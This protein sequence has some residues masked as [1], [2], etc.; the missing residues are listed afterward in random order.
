M[1]RKGRCKAAFGID[2][3]GIPNRQR[4]RFVPN[5]NAAIS[6]NTLENVQ[7]QAN[8]ERAK[9]A[10][11]WANF[12]EMLGA[13]MVGKGISMAGSALGSM[14][15][16]AIGGTGGQLVNNLIT[17]GSQFGANLIANNAMFGLGG[18]VGG[19]LPIEIEGDETVEYPDG[20]V[21]QY[22]GPS[23]E[24]GG[25]PIDVPAGSEVYSKRIKKYNKT[26]S[27]RKAERTKHEDKIQRRS[28]NNKYDSLLKA[29][30]GKTSENNKKIDEQDKAV[31]TMI[32]DTITINEL[33]NRYKAAYGIPP[34]LDPELEAVMVKEGLIPS[35]EERLYGGQ[36]KES[37][38]A[39]NMDDL[40]NFTVTASRTPRPTNI[41]TLSTNGLMNVGPVSTSELT[42][43]KVPR[44][45]EPLSPVSYP[46]PNVFTDGLGN[47]APSTS[48]ITFPARRP[49]LQ[50]PVSYPNMPTITDGVGSASPSASEITLP[51]GK[52][53]PLDPIS[54]SGIPQ[55]TVTP[56]IT[57]KS[58]GESIPSY[59]QD[60]I[61]PDYSGA[62]KNVGK[63]VGNAVNG[64]LQNMPNAAEMFGMY[65]QIK[66]ANDLMNN[67]VQNLNATQ[68]NINPYE[69]YGEEGLN[70]LDTMAKYFTA[71][72]D[73]QYQNLERSRNAIA[74]R[75]RN[76]ARGV[77]TL[78]ALD[79]I[80]DAQL[81]RSRE[82][83]DN[84]YN[85]Q[86][87]NLTQQ[88]SN[89]QNQRDRMFMMGE[90]QRDLADR[91]DI[92]NYYTNRAQDLSTRYQVYQNLAR[93]MNDIRNQRESKSLIEAMS[94]YGAKWD[95]TQGK[96]VTERGRQAELSQNLATPLE[97]ELR[98]N[99]ALYKARSNWL[100]AANNKSTKK[101]KKK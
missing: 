19:V 42:L 71:Q 82:S 97:A 18:Q 91:Q 99:A 65:S 93:Q 67:T 39:Y 75:N 7:A 55:L 59:H 87:A 72:R 73:N 95:S 89:L 74:E 40:D 44:R 9:Y 85:Q 30:L 46:M 25:I 22:T 31:Q 52:N 20:S 3:T 15:G 77:N 54:P 64:V 21:V 37:A 79:L 43:A 33:N 45:P 14:A 96:W 8:M 58:L 86:M 5:Y 81:Q 68:P 10:N 80:S 98:A 60:R 48:E 27:D 28:D 56:D 24:S 17:N 94:P 4:T 47:A 69:H 62:L 41:P 63:A 49:I 23:H 38:G 66:G 70:T 53:I 90:Q 36:Y 92:D 6:A 100:N 76:S 32:R 16:N 29:T 101:S 83:I 88:K 50:D 12:G 2:T 51:F 78:R 34:E 13:N 1:R 11:D 84:A 26:L 57:F 61:K 35:K